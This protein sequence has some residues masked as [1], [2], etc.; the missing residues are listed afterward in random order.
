MTDLQKEILSRFSDKQTIE[1][2]T[3]DG[4]QPRIR[5]MTLI[6]FRQRFFIATGSTDAKAKQ[7]QENPLSEILY[8][9]HTETNSGYVRLAGPL[10]MV[11]DQILRKEVAD[12]SGFIYDYWDNSEN[13][14]FLLL[15]MIP[16]EAQLMHPGDMN[17]HNIIWETIC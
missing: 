15:E 12:F 5:P 4:L 8:I 7:I 10:K 1:L 11:T 17:A 2:A 14:S 9:L 6:F 13:P 16:E 3:C